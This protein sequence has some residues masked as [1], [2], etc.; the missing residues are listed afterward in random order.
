MV[1]LNTWI[2]KQTKKEHKQPTHKKE[3]NEYLYF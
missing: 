3:K 2:I 1:I